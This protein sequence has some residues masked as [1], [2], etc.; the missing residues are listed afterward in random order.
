MCENKDNPKLTQFEMQLLKMFIAPRA[1][2][3]LSHYGAEYTPEEQ[4]AKELEEDDNIQRL[5]NSLNYSVNDRK[6]GK[7]TG[8]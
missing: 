7:T 1:R 8:W 5:L 4:I 6:I 2:P 3:I